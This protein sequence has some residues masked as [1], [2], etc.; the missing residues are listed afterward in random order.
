MKNFPAPGKQ[1]CRVVGDDS[2]Y[3]E[4]KSPLDPARMIGGPDCG[5]HSAMTGFFDELIAAP[6]KPRP[7]FAMLCQYLAT[8]NLSGNALH[9]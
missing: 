2:V 6:G 5:Q 9:H 7:G 1:A 4:V 3:T 8:W